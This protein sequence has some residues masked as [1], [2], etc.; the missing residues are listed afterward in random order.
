MARRVIKL[1]QQERPQQETK[2]EQ[3]PQSKRPEVDSGSG[4]TSD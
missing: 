3:S 2:A 4:V 1:R